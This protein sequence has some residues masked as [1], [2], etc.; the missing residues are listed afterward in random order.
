MAMNKTEDGPA[1]LVSPGPSPSKAT[2]LWFRSVR[3]SDKQIEV[4]S[5]ESISKYAKANEPGVDSQR[6]AQDPCGFCL[7]CVALVAGS[8]I[9][10]S[11]PRLSGTGLCFSLS[12]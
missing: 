3:L 7:D 9:A 2:A 12:S 6:T 10:A 5:L 1:F 11:W 4:E 8:Q